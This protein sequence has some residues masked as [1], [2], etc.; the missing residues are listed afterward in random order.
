MS[1]L[2]YSISP[3]TDQSGS[4]I[5]ALIADVFGEYENCPFIPE[6]FTELNSVSTFYRAKRGEIWIAI[7]NNGVLVGCLALIPN[8]SVGT[9]EIFKVYVARTAR[10]TGLA[11]ELYNTGLLWGEERGLKRLRLWTD[12]RFASGHRFYEKLGFTKQPVIRY[13]GDAAES[14][15][16]LYLCNNPTLALKARLDR[17]SS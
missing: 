4:A 15:E 7:D 14:W 1:P 3:A 5:G 8:D 2:T 12:T 17:R 16:Y 9:F 11:Q 10:G 6:E 13:L